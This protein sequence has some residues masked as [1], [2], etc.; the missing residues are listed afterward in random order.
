MLDKEQ[1]IGRVYYHSSDT[2]KEFGLRTSTLRFYIKEGIIP[3]YDLK[4]N[5]ASKNKWKID[6]MEHIR[7]VFKMRETGYYT[8]KGLRELV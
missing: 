1:K 3:D 8:L 6:K 2:R 5:S 7:K 4:V